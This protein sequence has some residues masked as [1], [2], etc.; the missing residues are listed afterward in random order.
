MSQAFKSFPSTPCRR[1]Q[2]A[3]PVPLVTVGLICANQRH[4]PDKSNILPAFPSPVTDYYIQRQRSDESAVHV[5]FPGLQQALPISFP[6]GK[7]SREGRGKDEG[8]GEE[9]GGYNIS[10]Q[11]LRCCNRHGPRLF[12]TTPTDTII[13]AKILSCYICRLG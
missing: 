6:Q 11:V 5:S 12:F 10:M 2:P 3:A 7:E 4:M 8:R 1:L 9:E 13:M